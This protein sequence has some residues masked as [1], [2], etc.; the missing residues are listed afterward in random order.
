MAAKRLWR[1]SPAKRKQ[2]TLRWVC[3]K[4]HPRHARLGVGH[5]RVDAGA[6][7]PYAADRP[8]PQ[9]PSR[10]ARARPRLGPHL[11]LLPDPTPCHPSSHP[12]LQLHVAVTISDPPPW[13][14]PDATSAD[15]RRDRSPKGQSQG[16][17]AQRL[18]ASRQPP[19]PLEVDTGRLSHSARQPAGESGDAS[20]ASDRGGGRLAR[21][22]SDHLHN[23]TC[24]PTGMRLS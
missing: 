24:F 5:P 8:R 15:G 9:P 17:A 19:F 22:A 21:H 1:R 10:A 2:A 13:P 18:T 4:R 20:S 11:S 3:N 6:A 14:D 7:D 16:P 12:G 23:P